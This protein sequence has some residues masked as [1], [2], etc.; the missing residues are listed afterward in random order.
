MRKCHFNL[1]MAFSIEN[2]IFNW[3]NIIFVF[4]NL[5]NFEFHK[6]LINVNLEF[7][8]LNESWK[9]LEIF[10]SNLMA[11]LLTTKR[12]SSTWDNTLIII[13]CILKLEKCYVLKRKLQVIFNW[14]K[15]WFFIEKMW[16]LNEKM[17][18]L[19]KKKCQILLKKCH[20]HI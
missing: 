1:K 8:H 14:K 20:F 15:W 12:T 11:L 13:V 2:G 18:F 7:L 5:S 10:S 16:F 17:S 6:I 9:I 4:T 19:I 3:K